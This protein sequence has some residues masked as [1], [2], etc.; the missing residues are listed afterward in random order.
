MATPVISIVK[1]SAGFILD[2][3]GGLAIERIGE[4]GAQ[5]FE[6]DLVDAATDFLVGGEQQTD[7]AVADGAIL[8][9]DFGGGDDFGNAGLVVGAQQRRT[10]RGDDV[11]ADLVGQFRV[12]GHLD[13]AAGIAQRDVA[14]GIVGDD[15][16]PHVGAAEIGR[17]IHM[18][19]EADDRHVLVG[20][21][22]NGGIDIAVSVQVRVVEADG[23]E[24]LHQEAAEILLLFRRGLGGG[25]FVSL[26]IDHDI[27]QKAI[28]DGVGHGGFRLRWGIAASQPRLAIG[29][30]TVRGP[31]YAKC[32]AR[33]T[34]G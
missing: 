18:R 25:G 12:L 15:L 16:G 1:A 10:I 33:A 21:G 7:L 20:I 2:G 14:A 22:R 8:H 19:A 28:E 29:V 9:E 17:G 31:C 5:L 3:A 23:Q 26:R 32:C 4:A 30:A 13:D 34:V 27:A 24:F 6:I 11:V